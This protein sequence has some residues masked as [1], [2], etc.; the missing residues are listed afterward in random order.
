M[1]F[2]VCMHK[3]IASNSMITGRYHRAY[4]TYRLVEITDKIENGNQ[5]YV[6]A[7][8]IQP[9]NRKQLRS[10]MGHTGRK[11]EAGFSWPVNKMCTSSVKMDVT[12]ASAGV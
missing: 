10:S 8:T 11:S 9:K 7:T 6:K 5:E 12:Q 1:K 4:I 3:Q 2:F